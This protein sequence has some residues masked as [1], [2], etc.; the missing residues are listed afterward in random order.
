MS[1]KDVPPSPSSSDVL[2]QAGLRRRWR[3]LK[4]L[5]E[6]WPGHDE[7]GVHAHLGGIILMPQSSEARPGTF[8]NLEDM[9]CRL[10]LRGSML[11]EP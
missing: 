11:D 2:A 1:W 10:L 7:K 5:C 6:K 8:G 3:G 4:D 9:R